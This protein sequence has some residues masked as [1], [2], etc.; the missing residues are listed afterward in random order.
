MLTLQAL[1]FFLILQKNPD[2]FFQKR[3]FRKKK[4]NERKSIGCGFIIRLIFSVDYHIQALSIGD[5][6]TS[7]LKV[8]WSGKGLA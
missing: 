3:F 5:E 1:S 6:F 4:K 8:V 2:A 7:T